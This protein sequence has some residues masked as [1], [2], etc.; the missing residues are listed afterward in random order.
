[1]LSA[2]STFAQIADDHCGDKKTQTDMN[3]C[4]YQAADGVDHQVRKS[5]SE[6]VRKFQTIPKALAI[7]RRAQT[8]WLKFRKDECALEGFRTRD[9]TVNGWVVNECYEAY[10]QER[11]KVLV[12]Q[13]DCQEG[14]LTCILPSEGVAQKK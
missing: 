8:D 14:D 13:L 10:A 7:L 3:L 4:S 12:S 6:L 1:V 9:G 11:L 5:Y 2:N